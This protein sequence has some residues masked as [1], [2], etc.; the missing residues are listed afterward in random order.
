MKKIF[1]TLLILCLVI[2]ILPI[3]A[4]AETNRY[5]IRSDGTCFAINEID[6]DI[7]YDAEPGDIVAVVYNDFAINEDMDKD[8]YVTRVIII[9]DTDTEEEIM[10]INQYQFFRMPERNITLSAEIK[11]RTDVKELK[12]YTGKYNRI[13]D[14][15]LAAKHLRT[16]KYAMKVTSGMPPLDFNRDGKADAVFYEHMDEPDV[17]SYSL[18]LTDA[19]RKLAGKTYTLLISEWDP[20]TS[21]RSVK[22]KLIDS[23]KL[24]LKTV[25]VK[26]SAKKLTLSATVKRLGKPAVGKKVTF[27]FKGKKYTAKTNKYGVAKV[28]IKRK[29][30]RKLKVGKK[31][32]YSV[33]YAKRIIKKTA[34]VKR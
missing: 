12:L 4:S 20:W 32:T 1:S 34:K 10:R 29:V 19:G 14:I 3:S 11:K 15:V 23:I 17:F 30:L 13:D 25:K 26:R 8:L 21:C 18:K 22:I 9:K 16:C 28:T 6:E 5:S 31:V 7:I 2:A 33:T 24:T 27:K